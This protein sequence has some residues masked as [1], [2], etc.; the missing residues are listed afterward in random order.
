MQPKINEYLPMY[1]I[2]SYKR[3]NQTLLQKLA[4]KILQIL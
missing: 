4:Q 3:R 2:E 1:N